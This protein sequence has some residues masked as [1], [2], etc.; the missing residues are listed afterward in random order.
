MGEGEE[1]VQEE[2]C[3]CWSKLTFFVGEYG[4]DWSDEHHH[5]HHDGEEGDGVAGHP[6]DKDIQW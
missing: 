3:D 6:Q 4:L 2:G 1:G 5:D